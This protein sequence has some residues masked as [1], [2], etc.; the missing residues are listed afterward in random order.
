MS[1]S[2]RHTLICTVGTS[3]F[4]NLGHLTDDATDAT[5]AAVARAYAEKN[6]PGVAAQLRCLAPSDRDCGAE[7]NSVADLLAHYHVEKGRLHLLVSE[8]RD[9]AALATVLTEYFKQDGWS[10]NAHPIEGLRDDDPKAFRTRGL[11]NLAKVI[12]QR[13]RESGADFC[14]I[15]AT[16]GYKAQI[17][18]AVLMGQALDIPVYYKHERFD[19]IIRFPPMPVSL[20]FSLWQKASG[21]FT[22][23]S[24]PNACEPSE[25]FIEDWDERFEPLINRD[26][27]DGKSYLELSAT[28][29]IFHETF[30]TRFQQSKSIRLPRDAMPTERQSPNLGHHGYKQARE[31]LLRYLRRLSQDRPYIR[32]C[33]ATYWNPDLPESTRF[34]SSADEV[35]G[36]YSNGSWCVKFRVLTTAGDH[37]DPSVVVA[38]LNAWLEARTG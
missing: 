19:A 4:N 33:H 24:Q 31:P 27:I 10:V 1:A 28:G 12:G 9:G 35:Q 8:T 38:D 14:A 36:I 34:R 17:A 6:W 18:I 13:V 11:R 5:R 25:R 22:V 30:R 16:G 32:L 37:D 29:Q 26:N 3:L 15:N 23:L 7:I 2:T 20:D 21:M